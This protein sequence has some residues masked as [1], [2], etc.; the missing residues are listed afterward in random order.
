VLNITSQLYGWRVKTNCPSALGNPKYCLLAGLYSQ[1]TPHVLLGSNCSDGGGTAPST[2]PKYTGSAFAASTA[3]DIKDVVLE[4]SAYN[5]PGL[6]SS[7][8]KSARRMCHFPELSCVN[9]CPSKSF[10]TKYTGPGFMKSMVCLHLITTIATHK[11][12]PMRHVGFPTLFKKCAL[13]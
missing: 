2:R 3:E 5:R 12:K 8:G 10:R 1:Y 11:S 4:G 9:V 6:V 13:L 7:G